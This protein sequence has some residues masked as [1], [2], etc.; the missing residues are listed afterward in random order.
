MINPKPLPLEEEE[1]NAS[2]PAVHPVMASPPLTEAAGN[3]LRVRMKEVQG[4]PA[5]PGGLALRL[6]Q[7]SLAAAALCLMVTTAD[8]ASVTAFWYLL[9]CMFSSFFLQMPFSFLFLI[10]ITFFGFSS[11][12]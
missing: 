6:S 4:S 3:P 7:S 8:F 5:T 2:R 1:M 10:V 12:F 9:T 11:A